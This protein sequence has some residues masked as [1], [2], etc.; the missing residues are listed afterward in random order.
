V[1]RD[2]DD[3]RRAQ[4]VCVHAG[5]AHF[6]EYLREVPENFR[7][8]DQQEE[9]VEEDEGEEVLVVPV[10]QAV[11]YEG[12]VM[13]KALDA[14]IANSAVERCLRFDNFAVGAQVVQVQSKIQ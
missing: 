5:P 10:A 9:E 11:I 8:Q 12:T 2:Q 6:F 1:E 4:T 3:A 14:L 7:Q 13:V